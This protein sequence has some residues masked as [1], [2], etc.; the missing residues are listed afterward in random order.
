MST[1]AIGL[2]FLGV[3]SAT[4]I[5]LGHAAAV[6]EIGGETLLIDCGPETIARFK[7]RYRDLGCTLPDAVFITHCHLDH[8]GDLENLFIQAWFNSAGR[9]QI[10]MFVPV[11]LIPL[12]QQRV[13]TYPSVL[14]EGGVNFWDAFQLIPVS[15]SFH[16]AGLVFTVL[17]VRH[18]A[19]DSAF[20]LYLPHAFFYTG[21]TRPV[22]EVLAH[23]VDENTAI[24]HDCACVGNP[25]HTGI[26]DMLREYSEALRARIYC[27]HYAN[28][29]Q[30][31]VFKENGLRA[32][33]T[34]ESFDFCVHE[35]AS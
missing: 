33:T 29:E 13:A 7:A 21:D 27:Y 34:G 18:H 14:A 11:S 15:S 6:V 12:L 20:G 35:N 8:I 1:L 17:A 22:P 26:D 32:V 4:Q 28:A 2:H 16:F 30:A 9:K 19:P 3:G 23:S 31:A 10:K 25:S 24:F 5:G